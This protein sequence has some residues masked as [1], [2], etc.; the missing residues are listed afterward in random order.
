VGLLDMIFFLQAE[1]GI[2]VL[3][4]TGVQTCALPIYQLLSGARFA[5]EQDGKVALHHSLQ[6]LEEAPHQRRIAEDL[7]ELARSAGL[8]LLLRSE[9]RRVGKVCRLLPMLGP[10]DGKT[11]HLVVWA[12]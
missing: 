8:D 6:L 11:V 7:R 12:L 2:R 10:C 1:D 5:R 3:T 4:V 9:E